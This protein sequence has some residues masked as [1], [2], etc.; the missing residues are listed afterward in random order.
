MYV[1][2]YIYSQ[3]FWLCHIIQPAGLFRLMLCVTQFLKCIVITQTP[4][5]AITVSWKSISVYRPLAQIII[6][7]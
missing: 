1:Y 2:L 6:K 7:S 5:R 3:T 4:S